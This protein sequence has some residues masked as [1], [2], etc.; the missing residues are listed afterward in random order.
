MPLNDVSQ[1][2]SSSSSSVMPL[3]VSYQ[4]DRRWASDQPR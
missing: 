1:S 2:E 3:A 4:I